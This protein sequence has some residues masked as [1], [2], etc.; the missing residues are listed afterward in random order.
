MIRERLT[1]D[2]LAV[3]W[4]PTNAYLQKFSTIGLRTLCC[5]Y[6]VIPRAEFIAWYDQMQEA[7][8]SMENRAEAVSQV[9]EI[10]EAGFTLLGTTAIEDRLQEGV[11]EA[12]ASLALAGIKL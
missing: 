7:K 1:T 8:S 3:S 9:S 2:S 10:I 12:I 5:A 6:R 4:L 11:P